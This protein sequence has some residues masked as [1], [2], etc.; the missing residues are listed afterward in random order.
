MTKTNRIFKEN[1]SLRPSIIFKKGWSLST[2]KHGDGIYAI[3]IIVD[4]DSQPITLRDS[5][6]DFVTFGSH[7]EAQEAVDNN[8]PFDVAV[9]CRNELLSVAYRNKVL[10][11]SFEEGKILAT[12][13]QEKSETCFFEIAK[14]EVIEAYAN[15]ADLKEKT[16]Y[17]V[18]CVVSDWFEKAHDDYIESYTDSYFRMMGMTND[19]DDCSCRGGGCVR[20]EP[21]RFL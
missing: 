16:L 11:Y 21:N 9:E 12:W 8:K 6:G 2:E 1:Y 3:N 14:L 7:Q 19:N 13:N 15:L 5:K 18:E 17:E 20:C 10:E 4:A